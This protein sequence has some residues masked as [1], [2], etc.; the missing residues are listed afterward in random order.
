MSGGSRIGDLQALVDHDLDAKNRWGLLKQVD[1]G[2]TEG[3]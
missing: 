2:K 3:K 1:A